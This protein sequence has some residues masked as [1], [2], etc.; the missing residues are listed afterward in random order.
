[1]LAREV[2]VPLFGSS[3]S[4]T[5]LKQIL[6]AQRRIE[7][8]LDAL[9]S[10]L[11]VETELPATPASRFGLPADLRSRIEA[12][13]HRGNKIMAIKL[14]REATDLGLAEAKDAIESGDY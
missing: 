9:L 5:E 4:D 14:L 10:A 3:L 6:E 8:K 2:P 12:E 13:V 7:R 1:M 11:G